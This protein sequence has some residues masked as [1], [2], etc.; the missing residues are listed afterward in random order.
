[1]IRIVLD[2]NV[3]V[4]GLLSGKGPPGQIVDF[5]LAGEIEVACDRR[6]LAEYRDVLARP[7]LRIDQKEAEDVLQQIE[8]SAMV[9][10]PEPWL[11]PLPDADDEAFLAV[12]EASQA[13]CLVTGNIRHFPARAR[14]DVRVL[15]PRQFVDMLSELE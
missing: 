12:A 1:V 8:H 14:R 9:V 6:I 4:A 11:E 15:T 2:T 3:L 7:E 13:I 5:I 10:T